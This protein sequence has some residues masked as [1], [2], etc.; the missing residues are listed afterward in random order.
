MEHQVN[1]CNLINAPLRVRCKKCGYDFSTYFDDFDID[2]YEPE[3]AGVWVLPVTCAD[4]ET[5]QVVVI[6]C[7]PVR[8][9][10]ASVPISEHL[11]VA[12]TVTQDVEDGLVTV[13]CPAI[14]GCYAQGRTRDEALGNMPAIIKARLEA[15]LER[16]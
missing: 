16:P 6:R 10:N 3:E 8:V 1:L 11:A 5:E 4:C 14:R 13:T 12:V 9:E 7:G 2:T 15:S